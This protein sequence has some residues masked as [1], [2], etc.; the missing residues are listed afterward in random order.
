M[1]ETGRIP[2]GAAAGRAPPG[3]TAWVERGKVPG[4]TGCGVAA[5]GCGPIGR[6]GGIGRGGAIGRTWRGIKP[7]AAGAGRKA[8]VGPAGGAGAVGTGEG[9][10]A[11]AAATAGAAGGAGGAGGAIGRTGPVTRGGTTGARMT[12]GATAGAGAAA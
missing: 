9:A 8:M 4:V 2:T 11:A 10:G 6:G 7:E 3:D 1:G 5:V 12:G